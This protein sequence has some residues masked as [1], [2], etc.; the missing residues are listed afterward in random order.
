MT[1]GDLNRIIPHQNGGG[2]L[3]DN[4]T[5]IIVPYDIAGQHDHAALIF[6]DQFPEFLPGEG[7]RRDCGEEGQGR[8]AVYLKGVLAGLLPRN[9]KW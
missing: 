9:A 4:I 5:P 8:I 2:L 6:T 7:G 3:H 1:L